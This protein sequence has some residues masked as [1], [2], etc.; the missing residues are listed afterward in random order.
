[1]CHDSSY[2]W[3]L[4]PAHLVIISRLGLGALKP[5]CDRSGIRG[6]LTVGRKLDRNGQNPYLLT[7]LWFFLNLSWSC[8]T[9]LLGRRRTRYPSLDA[10]VASGAPMK[11][12]SIEHARTSRRH[13]LDEDWR[14]PP[15]SSLLQDKGSVEVYESHVVTAPGG[16]CGI[17]PTITGPARISVLWVVFVIAFT[18]MTVCN[19]PSWEY[20]GDKLGTW[21][22]KRLWQWT[23]GYSS[24][25]KYPRIVPSQG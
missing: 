12:T 14:G 13:W 2:V 7:L 22:H 8:L 5:G 11:T 23:G 4:V 19:L 1:M 20:S 10:F 18:V 15:S 21:G 25:Y 9:F 3:D 16:P 6:I 24:A 17:C